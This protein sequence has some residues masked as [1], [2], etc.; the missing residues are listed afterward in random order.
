MLFDVKNKE[1]IGGC[2]FHKVK[3]TKKNT[4]YHADHCL[5]LQKSN[6]I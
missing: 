2:A 1:I 6:S 3:T 5:Q 4:F